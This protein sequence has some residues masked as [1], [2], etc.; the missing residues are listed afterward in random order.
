VP[1]PEKIRPT[2]SDIL[3]VLRQARPDR[4]IGRTDLAHGIAENRGTEASILVTNQDVQAA[5]S[6]HVMEQVL[7]QLVEA[8]QVVQVE[9]LKNGRHVRSWQ[10]AEHARSTA[11][12][13]AAHWAQRRRER[14]EQ[15]ARE[16]LARRYPQEFEGLV[17]VQLVRG[18]DDES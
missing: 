10:A 14:A 16:E 1:R 5:V 7:G 9:V 13:E 18:V 17:A 4:K 8:G 15:A 6:F 12:A 3:A 11:D 2:A